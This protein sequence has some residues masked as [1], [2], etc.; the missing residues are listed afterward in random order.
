MKDRFRQKRICPNYTIR[1]QKPLVQ[2]NGHQ[3]ICGLVEISNLFEKMAK[4]S[5]LFGRQVGKTSALFRVLGCTASPF[6]TDREQFQQEFGG[7]FTNPLPQPDCPKCADGQL[8]MDLRARGFLCRSCG[9]KSWERGPYYVGIDHSKEKDRACMVIAHKEG[10]DMV[11]DSVSHYC[12]E[13]GYT[14]AENS[15]LAFCP[16]CEIEAMEQIDREG[17][18]P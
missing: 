15:G 10:P 2:L 18:T 4:N 12:P 3:F 13:H 7:M 8:T 14:P 11:V 6:A 17:A 9:Y 5:T 1:I 16:F